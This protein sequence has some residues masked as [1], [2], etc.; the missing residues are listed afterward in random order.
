MTT[1]DATSRQDTGE[2]SDTTGRDRASESVP[3]ESGHSTADTEAR[4]NQEN[5]SP[6]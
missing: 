6:S 5:E 4:R 2:G 3:T 1:D